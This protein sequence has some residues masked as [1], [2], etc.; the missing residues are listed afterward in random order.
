VKTPA[1]F[2]IEFARSVQMHACLIKYA[3]ADE[4]A[5]NFEGRVRLF[6]KL[7]GV[8]RQFRRRKL[9]RTPSKRSS[10]IGRQIS[11]PQVSR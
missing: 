6:S 1:P 7:I 9:R 2:A 8:P 3:R 5:M 11:Y 10:V 4:F